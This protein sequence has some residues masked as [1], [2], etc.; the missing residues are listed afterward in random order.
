MAGLLTKQ[1]LFDRHNRME[2]ASTVGGSAPSDGNYYASEG[3]T[4][5]SPFANGTGDHMVD[6][7]TSNVQSENSGITYLSSP[8]LGVPP[9]HFQD[10]HPGATDTFSGQPVNSSLGQFGGP[11]NTQGPCTTGGGFC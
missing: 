5:N 1:S 7:L 4:I 8:S 2:L 3:Q 6:L 10:L 9:G 11:Y